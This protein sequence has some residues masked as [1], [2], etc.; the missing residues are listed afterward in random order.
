[1]SNPRLPPEILDHIVDLLHD[2]EDALK[3]CCLVSK[4]WIPRTRKHLFANISFT[5][6][7]GLQTW[8]E[9]FPEPS[10]S[11][12]CYTETLFVGCLQDVTATDAE[13]GG[14]IRGFS[15]VVYLKLG[16]HWGLSPS[17]TFV[18][19]YGFSPTIKSLHVNYVG[20]RSSQVFNLILSFP[21]LEDLAVTTY[22]EPFIDDSKDSDGLSTTIQPSSSPMLTG[23]LELFLSG[24]MEPVT[25]RL[26]SLQSGIHFRDLTLTWRFGVEL[27]EVMRLVERCSHTLESLTIT[28]H[29]LG[30]S[31]RH[32]HP[33]REL[34][35]PCSQSSR[36]QLRSTFPSDEA[37]TCGLS[38]RNVEH[39]MGHHST[40]NRYTRTSGLPTNLDIHALLLD[41]CQHRANCRNDL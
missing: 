16:T 10:N 17:V 26:L 31:V 35:C 28:R 37:Q 7:E 36:N 2:T 15:R 3:N 33:H 25:R 32:S 23:S 5:T 41:P 18:P 9:T 4:S 29:P 12:A 34:T 38:D 24:L 39:R 6:K 20:F 19:F 40:P 1:M 27:V 21:L 22:Y 11:P 13:A 30:T 14:W 8:R